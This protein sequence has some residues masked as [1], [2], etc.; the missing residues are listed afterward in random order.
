MSI[1]YTNLTCRQNS[2]DAT[3]VAEDKAIQCKLNGIR[4]GY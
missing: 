3:M 4:R 1:P 2:G